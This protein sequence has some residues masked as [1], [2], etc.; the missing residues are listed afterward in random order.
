MKQ[1]RFGLVMIISVALVLLM[2]SCKKS[3]SNP[4]NSNNPPGANYGGGSLSF[5][6]NSS[7][8]GNFNLSGSFNP[9]SYGSSGSGVMCWYESSANTAIVYGYVWRSSSDWDLVILEFNRPTGTALG[10]GSY[11]FSNQSAT[12]IFI[13]GA[14]GMSASNGNEYVLDEGTANMTSY[15]STGMKGNFSGTGVGVTG[16]VV[17]QAIQVTNGSFDVTF[18]TVYGTP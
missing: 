8:V 1:L 10:T 12:L 13:K 5:N 18:G 2:A 17:G 4:T 16:A 6:T 14:N 15:S 11:S 3:D 9:T 7:S